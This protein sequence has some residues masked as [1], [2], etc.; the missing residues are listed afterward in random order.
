MRFSEE[1]K[2]ALKDRLE[3]LATRYFTSPEEGLSAGYSPERVRRP[4]PAEIG[5]PRRMMNRRSEYAAWLYGIAR[6]DL[7]P[8]TWRIEEFLGEGPQSAFLMIL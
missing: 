3:A 8:G 1:Q 7:P 4:G 5:Q 6:K 2:T